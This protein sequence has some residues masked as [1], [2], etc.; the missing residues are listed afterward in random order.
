MVYRKGFSVMLCIQCLQ[1]RCSE[2]KTPGG[3]GDIEDVKFL[4][5]V[6]HM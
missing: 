3:C 4:L 5:I 1:E 2:R 6:S